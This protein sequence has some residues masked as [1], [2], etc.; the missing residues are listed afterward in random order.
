PGNRGYGGPVAV[1]RGGAGLRPPKEGFFSVVPGHV[2]VYDP[3]GKEFESPHPTPPARS[4]TKAAA[5]SPGGPQ[6]E[7][8]TT[9]RLRTTARAASRKGDG[10]TEA[11]CPTL[12]H[13]QRPRRTRHKQVARDR[14]R[15]VHEEEGHVEDHQHD[16]ALEEVGGHRP[17]VSGSVERADPCAPWNR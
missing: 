13:S 11:L 6:Q 1:P 14:D 15:E 3:T 10:K 4:P 2:P 12:Q 7:E 16:L 17:G 9:T 8:P 5:Y